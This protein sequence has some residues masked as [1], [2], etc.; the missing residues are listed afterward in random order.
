M[1]L[2]IDICKSSLDC[3]PSCT[4]QTSRIECLKTFS[5]FLH[6]LIMIFKNI[7]LKFKKPQLPVKCYG[8]K[9]VALYI[10]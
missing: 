8:T 5:K 1:N 2:Q 3:S 6:H 9:T 4:R 7:L 10:K